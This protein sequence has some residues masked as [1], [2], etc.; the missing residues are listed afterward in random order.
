MVASGLFLVAFLHHP[1][2]TG[3]KFYGGLIGITALAG[4]GVSGWHIW[5]QNL[6]PEEVPSCG[7]GLDFIMG[8]FPLSE[9]LAMVFSGSGECAEISWQFLGLSIPAWTLLAFIGMLWLVWLA[10]AASSKQ[11]RRLF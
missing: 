6:P 1:K 9:A 10:I 5:L 4:A 8:N 3:T 11:H 7:P 2:H